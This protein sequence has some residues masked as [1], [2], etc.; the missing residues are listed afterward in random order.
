MWN[1]CFVFSILCETDSFSASKVPDIVSVETK[2]DVL[3]V[4]YVAANIV[5]FSDFRV[6]LIMCIML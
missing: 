4:A 6:K 3:F 2:M 1:Y 5:E